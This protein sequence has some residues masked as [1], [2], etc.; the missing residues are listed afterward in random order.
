MVYALVH[1]LSGLF[2][3]ATKSCSCSS[4]GVVEPA[5]LAF[6]LFLSVF[7]YLLIVVPWFMLV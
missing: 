5:A 6:F 2:H 4:T 7:I 1:A 3:N